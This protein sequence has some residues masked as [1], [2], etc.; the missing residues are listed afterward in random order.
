MSE[1]GKM[2]KP[3]WNTF[4]KLTDSQMLQKPKTLCKACSRRMV[5]DLEQPYQS[6]GLAALTAFAHQ[7][8]EPLDGSLWI[9]SRALL[10]RQKVGLR[11]AVLPV[12]VLQKLGR[13]G[14]RDQSAA[15]FSVFAA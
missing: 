1:Q 8:D 11:H 6:P 10:K 3:G 4:A 12:F 5:A 13:A 2:W 7:L 15:A 14:Q 9:R